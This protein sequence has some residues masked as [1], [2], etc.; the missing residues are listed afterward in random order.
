MR[1]I[2]RIAPLA[3]AALLAAN[4]A[5]AEPIGSHWQ[6][7]PFG[8]FTL[9]D[10]K[11]RFPGSNLPL[12]DDLY[13]GGGPCRRP[14]GCSH[15]ARLPRRRC[16]EPG[17]LERL[18]PPNPPAPPPNAADPPAAWGR[19]RGGRACQPEEAPALRGIRQ[20]DGI[21]S[22]RR[23]RQTRRGCRRP[24]DRVGGSDRDF[25]GTPNDDRRCCSRRRHRYGTSRCRGAALERAPSAGRTCR[26]LQCRQRSGLARAPL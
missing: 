19:D 22:P 13:V 17:S 21:D 7:T 18:R 11:L 23:P 9:F 26:N 6:L 1:S 25:E 2:L 8:G 10:P 5:V 15:A 3:L 20:R 16:P 14:P 24:R 4:A 12:T